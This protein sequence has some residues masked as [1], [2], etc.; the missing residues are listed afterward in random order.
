MWSVDWFWG[1][2]LRVICYR[3]VKSLST[4][5]RSKLSVTSK[6][7]W[8]SYDINIFLVTCLYCLSN[9]LINNKLETFKIVLHHNSLQMLIRPPTTQDRRLFSNSMMDKNLDPTLK[10]TSLKGK[11]IFNNTDCS[12]IFYHS[13]FPN[14]PQSCFSLSP[15]ILWVLL[16][17]RLQMSSNPMD[18]F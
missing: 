15:P 17:L 13:V 16:L 9:I 14:T 11:V 18:I 4:E 1:L 7:F 3:S 5:T 6:A 2:S 10:L 8:R 12:P